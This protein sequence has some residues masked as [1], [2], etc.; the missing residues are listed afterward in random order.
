MHRARIKNQERCTAHSSSTGRHRRGRWPR[1][2][3]DDV[4][5]VQA[6][7]DTAAIGMLQQR[8]IHDGQILTERLRQA[9][10]TGILIEQ[11]KGVVAQGTPEHQ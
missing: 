10:T 3:P 7:A 2:A 9:L 1:F 6:I 11:S 8:A 4:A 5:I